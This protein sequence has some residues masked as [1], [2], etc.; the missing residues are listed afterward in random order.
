[1][2]D[3]C[4]FCAI[5]DGD[6]PAE[7]V[8]RWGEALAIVPLNPVT[9]G[10]V[11]VLPK[12]HVTSAVD[13]VNVTAMTMRYAAK[14]AREHVGDCNI[15]TSVGPAATQTVKHLHVHVVPRV[16]GDGLALPWTGQATDHA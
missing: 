6:A 8:G 11:L 1:M 13:D 2:R 15:I 9:E 14:Y 7:I 12:V 3:A 5:V 16:S 10:H 4:P